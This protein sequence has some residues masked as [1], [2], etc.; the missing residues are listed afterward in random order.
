[1]PP[2]GI[3]VIRFPVS[4]GY[5]GD[6]GPAVEQAGRVHPG[7]GLRRR[8]VAH[9][10]SAAEVEAPGAVAV[11]EPGRRRRR[12]PCARAAA[13][14]RRRRG[15]GFAS[16]S[17]AAAPA[18]WGAA[19]EVPKNPLL[20][21]PSRGAVH[22]ARGGVGAG[23]VG[24]HPSVDGRPHG[25]EGLD[26]AVAVAV[27]AHGHGPVRHRGVADRAPGG[28][29]DREHP[30]VEEDVHAGCRGAGVAVDEHEVDA[31]RTGCVRDDGALDRRVVAAGPVLDALAARDDVA[32]VVLD[33]EVEVLGGVGPRIP[34]E[35]HERR[36]RRRRPGSRGRR[37]RPAC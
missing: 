37:H 34:L 2:A 22:A 13:A 18:T 1:M 6:A 31:V 12:R 4:P 28:R 26:G 21:Q 25:A 33:V 36:S 30:A 27:R 9:R 32:A 17:W 3:G 35:G 10:R 16:S 5:A 24:L 29:L 19:A 23:D 8:Q 7:E 14:A 15:R 20:V 11:V